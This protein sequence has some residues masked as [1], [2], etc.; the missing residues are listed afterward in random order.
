MMSEMCDSLQK[1]NIKA[2]ESSSDEMHT[3]DLAT[4]GASH[5]GEV[6]FRKI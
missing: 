5:H 3:E 6:D 4:D 2:Q 1:R